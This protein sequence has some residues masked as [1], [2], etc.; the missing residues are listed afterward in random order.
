MW[1]GKSFLEVAGT[2]EANLLQSLIHYAYSTR[3]PALRG[4]DR[5]KIKSREKAN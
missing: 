3:F 4:F 5:S 2:A 1:L